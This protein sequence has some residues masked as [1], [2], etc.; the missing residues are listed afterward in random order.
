MARRLY[1]E[2]DL[3]VIFAYYFGLP[4]LTILLLGL[5]VTSLLGI[6]TFYFAKWLLATKVLGLVPLTILDEMFLLDWDKNRANI[7]T[8]MKVDKVKDPE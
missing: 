8:V 5:N 6:A 1:S 2:V 7:L 3:C 4:V